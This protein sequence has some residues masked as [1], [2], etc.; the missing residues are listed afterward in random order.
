MLKRAVLH[1][2]NIKAGKVLKNM[3]DVLGRKTHKM[4]QQCAVNPGVGHHQQV[5]VLGVG[6]RGVKGFYHAGFQ[7][8]KIF[9]VGRALVNKIAVAGLNLRRVPRLYFLPVAAVPVAKTY[10]APIFVSFGFKFKVGGYYVS[11]FAAA[12]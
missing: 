6:Q 2:Y 1:V 3:E 10:F 4:G 11:R 9:A 7:I 5:A 8:H 12:P